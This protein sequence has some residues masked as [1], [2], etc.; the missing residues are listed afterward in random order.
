MRTFLLA[1]ITLYQR[2]LSP[3]L[4]PSCRFQ[5]SCSEYAR[6][7]V[8]QHGALKGTGLALSRLVRCHPLCRGGYDPVP[9]ATT[10]PRALQRNSNR[11]AA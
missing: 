1:L 6:D 10:A 5:P 11:H 8:Q 4:P 9:P 2:C 3:F 7:A